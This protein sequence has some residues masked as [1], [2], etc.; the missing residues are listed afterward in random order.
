MTGCSGGTATRSRP[1]SGCRGWGRAG[2]DPAAA[3]AAAAAGGGASEP[4]RTNCPAASWTFAQTLQ[5]CLRQRKFLS[6]IPLNP[7]GIV[8]RVLVASAFEHFF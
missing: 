7:D 2:A 1:G 5:L 4:Q 6:D 8:S 3:A